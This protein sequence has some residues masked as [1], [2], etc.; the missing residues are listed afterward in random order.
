M[1]ITL[2]LRKTWSTTG[3]HIVTWNDGFSVPTHLE[4]GWTDRQEHKSNVGKGTI[5]KY[6]LSSPLAPVLRWHTHPTQ[7]SLLIAKASSQRIKS[8][9]RLRNLAF[10]FIE[11]SNSAMSTPLTTASIDLMT[12]RFDMKTQC[13]IHP[14]DREMAALTDKITQL[15][16]GGPK[17][18]L[19]L[20]DN[21]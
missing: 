11:P 2:A 3:T 17:L 8:S 9:Q 6:V 12:G 13:H 4:L 5:E 20:P 15:L 21:V 10:Q 7:P 14:K 1:P 16:S 18:Y 19:W